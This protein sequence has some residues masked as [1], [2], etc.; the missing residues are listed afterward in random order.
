M[1]NFYLLNIKWF[2]FLGFILF[3]LQGCQKDDS[4][5]TEDES[6]YEDPN[7]SSGRF[8]EFITCSIISPPNEVGLSSYYKKYINCSGIPI[9]G[10]ADVPD[11]ALQIASETVEFMLT[12]LGNV[13]NKLISDGNYVALYPEG[14]SIGDLPEN[15][16]NN[17]NTG[18]YTNNNTLKAA[19]SDVASLLCRPEAGY[20]HTL[21]HEIAHMIDG[22][23]LRFISPASQS[24]LSN[25]YNQAISSGKWNNTY[26]STNP[27]EYL[28]EGV[29]IWYG[30][31]WIGP[32]GGDGLRNEIGTRGQ[33]QIYDSGLY[34]FINNYFNNK[35]AVPGCRE[36]VISGT[37]ANCPP[38]ITDIDGNEYEIVNIGPM[39]WMKE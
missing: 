29:T 37:T 16:T 26:A 27:Q 32:E 33:L 35:T 5:G 28:A 23:A 9:I 22:G 38:T 14:G 36:P 4:N 12:G 30:V 15:F 39:C 20:G 13:R 31:N 19:A 6:I 10:N 24:E 18:N 8:S 17:G 2:Y 7:N 11:E 25:L 34:N 1:K 21:V 3:T